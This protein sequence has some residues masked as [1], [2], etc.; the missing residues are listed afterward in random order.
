LLVCDEFEYRLVSTLSKGVGGRGTAFLSAPPDSRRC[1]SCRALLKPST[2][3]LT[4]MKEATDGV[5]GI[6]RAQ[7]AAGR[8]YAL[9]ETR[10]MMERGE[11]SREGEREG[12]NYSLGIDLYLHHL[13]CAPSPQLLSPRTGTVIPP[14]EAIR[15]RIQFKD[16]TFAYPTRPQNIVLH[17]FNLTVRLYLLL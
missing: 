7:G 13:I 14:A 8:L 17:N 12:E 11:G 10:P 9:L 3:H 15:G 6:I 4:A 2:S 1:C 5:A 16:V